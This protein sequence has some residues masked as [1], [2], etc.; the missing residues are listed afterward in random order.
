M[1]TCG[2]MK[3]FPF[4]VQDH[5]HC[6]HDVIL[7]RNN[8]LP[9]A[10]NTMR[11][12]LSKLKFLLC[13]WEAIRRPNCHT[14]RCIQYDRG[15][16][17]YAGQPASSPWEVLCHRT[18]C[19]VLIC[20]GVLLDSKAALQRERKRKTASPTFHFVNTSPCTSYLMWTVRT[21]T[22]EAAYLKSTSGCR[23]RW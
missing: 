13:H 23:W 19:G 1:R 21:V 20:Y 4:R 15:R 17:I 12:T 14:T 22:I 2:L 8:R 16:R 3:W 7:G 10:N 11:I 18:G 5:W 9:V 6:T